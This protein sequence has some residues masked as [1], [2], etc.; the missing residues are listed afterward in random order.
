MKFFRTF[1]AIVIGLFI[2]ATVNMSLIKLGNFLFPITGTFEEFYISGD[3]TIYHF[4]FPFL[5]HALGTLVGTLIAILISNDHKK[6]SSFIVGVFFLAGGISVNLMISS[7]LWYSVVDI[8]LAYIP[9]SL[10][11]NKWMISK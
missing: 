4:I 9:M 7:P 3:C 2:G 1:I 6:I 5:A 8:I 10:L 11:A